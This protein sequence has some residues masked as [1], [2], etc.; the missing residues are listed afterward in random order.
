MK[1]KV[2]EIEGEREARLCVTAD[3]S[4]RGK[5]CPHHI[6]VLSTAV[7]AIAAVA[8]VCSAH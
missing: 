5:D 3:W 8:I 1:V 7:T 4:V 2:R 6:H